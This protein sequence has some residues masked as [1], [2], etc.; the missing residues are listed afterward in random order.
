MIENL[1]FSRSSVPTSYF[2]SCRH[3]WNTKTTWNTFTTPPLRAE[4]RF[5]YYNYGRSRPECD[6]AEQEVD[7]PL[8]WKTSGYYPW[9]DSKNPNYVFHS[10]SVD[11]GFRWAHRYTP[12]FPISLLTSTF[13]TDPQGSSTATPISIQEQH[14]WFAARR[15]P[16]R[17]MPRPKQSK[18]TI[19]LEHKN[20]SHETNFKL[21][22]RQRK[23][24]TFNCYH[25]RTW[26]LIPHLQIHT[27]RK[28]PRSR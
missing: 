21:Q 1:I 25:H 9:R 19:F 15:S 8:I 22:P 28:K 26:W 20:S 14:H 24:I 10:Q 27:Q 6:S 18:K 17:T 11:Q 2:W 12:A 3:T 16:G 23:R 7:L 5:Q 4:R 13:H